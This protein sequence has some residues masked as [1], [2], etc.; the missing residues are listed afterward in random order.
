VTSTEGRIYA[1]WISRA[2]GDWRSLSPFGLYQDLGDCIRV[3]ARYLQIGFGEF[4][5]QQRDSFQRATVDHNGPG[6][7][8]LQLVCFKYNGNSYTVA[9]VCLFHG[10]V[11]KSIDFDNRTDDKIYAVLNHLCP[12]PTKLSALAR[13]L[14][15]RL[16]RL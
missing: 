4:T 7:S 5:L 12:S 13:G 3:V 16:E 2:M 9:L 1:E 14:S 8:Q 6:F 10:V 15:A 11:V